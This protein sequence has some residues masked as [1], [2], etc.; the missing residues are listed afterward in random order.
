M[1]HYKQIEHTLSKKKNHTYI[2]IYI[3]IGKITI[4][5]LQETLK[6]AETYYF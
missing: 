4:E 2:Y 5:Q 3:H 1:E 6:D